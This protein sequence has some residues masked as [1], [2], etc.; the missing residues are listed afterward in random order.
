MNQIFGQRFIMF[1]KLR[2]RGQL[3]LKL[4]AAEVATFF[5]EYRL[6]QLNSK[7]TKTAVSSTIQYF[8]GRSLKKCLSK[9]F[10]A[11][12]TTKWRPCKILKLK[13]NHLLMANNFKL[14]EYQTIGLMKMHNMC[15]S[16]MYFS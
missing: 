9:K 2:Y 7:H 1:E 15:K 3:L 4:R 11:P 14:H 10:F 16:K 5:I 6:D 12:P 13:G 8:E